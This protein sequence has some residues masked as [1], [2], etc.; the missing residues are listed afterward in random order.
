MTRQQIPSCVHARNL[1]RVCAWIL[2]DGSTPGLL[3]TTLNGGPACMS[4]RASS[5]GRKEWATSIRGR[6]QLRMSV[7]WEP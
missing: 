1:K 7:C 4:T 2:R 5:V 6:E 3:C